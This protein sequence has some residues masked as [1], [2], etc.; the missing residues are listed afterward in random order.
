MLSC[1]VSHSVPA[2]LHARA[3]KPR[4]SPRH[5]VAAVVWAQA[6]QNTQTHSGMAE[7]SAPADTSL[8]K[9]AATGNTFL[10]L[11]LYSVFLLHSQ[12]PSPAV[13]PCR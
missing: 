11:V 10:L 7:H 12:I 9:A 6:V 1:F 2:G 8:G 4:I 5:V 13:L 3:R